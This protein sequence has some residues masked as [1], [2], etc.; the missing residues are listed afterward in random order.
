MKIET[1]LEVG[2]IVYF[3]DRESLPSKGDCAFCGGRGEIT[4]QDAN[5]CNHTI[6]CPLCHGKGRNKRKYIYSVTQS[7]V[8]SI[9]IHID[10]LDKEIWYRDDENDW[11][12]QIRGTKFFK[13]RKEAQAYADELNKKEGYE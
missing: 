11:E 8:S 13:T 5:G 1:E 7:E 3:V 2:D 10:E 12:F 9:R 6:K 4:G